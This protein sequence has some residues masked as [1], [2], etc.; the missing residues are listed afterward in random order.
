MKPGSRKHAPPDAPGIESYITRVN[1][2]TDDLTINFTDEVS[3]RFSGGEVFMQAPPSLNYLRA[4]LQ[5]Q[6]HPGIPSIVEWL[7]GRLVEISKSKP[8][9]S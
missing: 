3:L 8:Y 5:Q 1:E 2:G 9:L 6:Y 4:E 7:N